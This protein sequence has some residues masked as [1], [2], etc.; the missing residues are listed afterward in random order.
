M[1]WL[2][3]VFVSIS[4]KLKTVMIHPDNVDVDTLRCGPIKLKR[5]CGSV[6]CYIF[7]F[8]K[9]KSIWWKTQRFLFAS[10]DIYF[11]GLLS[12][13]FLL[14]FEFFPKWKIQPQLS[15]IK[16]FGSRLQIY[17]ALA[18]DVNNKRIVNF[19]VKSFRIRSL[20]YGKV[21]KNPVTRFT[22][23]QKYILDVGVCC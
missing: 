2:V 14:V 4:N 8:S 3:N 5:S 13:H 7:V 11:I 12:F 10:N 9:Y 19:N 6:L 18:V 16:Y 22:F 20:S 1:E 15:L 21:A 23:K 17:D